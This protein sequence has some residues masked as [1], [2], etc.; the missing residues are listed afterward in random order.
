MKKM[1]SIFIVSFISL[2]SLIASNE[3]ILKIRGFKDALKETKTLEMRLVQAHVDPTTIGAFLGSET[4]A[5]GNNIKVKS[6]KI[7]NISRFLTDKEFDTGTIG[8]N[9]YEQGTIDRYNYQQHVLF[10]W[11]VLGNETGRFTINLEFSPFSQENNT[12][13]IPAFY[14][15]IYYS[16]IF[17]NQT[18]SKDGAT[19]SFEDNDIHTCYN[20]SGNVSLSRSW[21][22]TSNSDTAPMWVT[23]A[24]IL[25]AIKE[26]DY[27][28]ATLG[29]WTATCT[30][31][32]TTGN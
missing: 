11:K 3:A 12:N 17:D 26:S 8:V 4:D 10:Y 9:N 2:A 7:D 18:N 29:R 32:L 28:S 1:L 25:M 13:T 24:T 27:N 15:S 14:A 31:T 23:R 19:I 22:V 21:N 20:N 30:A 5:E 6:F 16:A